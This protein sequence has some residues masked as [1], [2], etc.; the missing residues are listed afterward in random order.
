MRG[1]S[2]SGAIPFDAL[3]NKLRGQRYSVAISHADTTNSHE[4]AHAP[5][6]AATLLSW[7]R[8]WNRRDGSNS[9]HRGAG[10]IAGASGSICRT[11]CMAINCS[12][13]ILRVVVVQQQEA[14]TIADEHCVQWLRSKA[15]L[16]CGCSAGHQHAQAH[17]LNLF[18]GFP[19]AVDPT[20]RPWH[21]SR[22]AG[23]G[24]E[25]GHTLAGSSA[26]PGKH[27]GLCNHT[28]ASRPHLLSHP[29]QST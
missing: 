21:S 4:T 18:C 29:C 2:L 9:C 15:A 17:R 10:G 16:V 1:H 7:P 11:D 25:R 5:S 19:A 22:L 24:V 3:H 13:L 27:E 8:A 23:G 12:P 26:V 20:V 28:L 14:A 6:S